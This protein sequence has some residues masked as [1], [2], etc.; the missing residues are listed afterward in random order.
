MKRFIGI[1]V[2]SLLVLAGCEQAADR[3]DEFFEP[4]IGTWESTIV[5][6]TTTLVFNAD[7]TCTE[8][9]SIGGVGTTKNGIW[10][11]NDSI[12]TRFFSDG[13]ADSFYYSFNSNKDE[14]TLSSSPG[15]PSRTYIEQ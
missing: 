14:L 10:G 6:E 8:T 13:S 12:I 5:D 3:I 4:I 1:T 15:G 11:A 7:E 2:L 9:V